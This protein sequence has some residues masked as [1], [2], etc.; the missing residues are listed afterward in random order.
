MYGIVNELRKIK[1]NKKHKH[2]LKNTPFEHILDAILH[3]KLDIKHCRKSDKDIEKIITLFN[4]GTKKFELNNIQ[5]QLQS[6]DV[7]LIFEI[8]DGDSKIEVGKRANKGDTEFIRR[9][10]KEDVELRKTTIRAEI[11]RAH[12]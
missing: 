12:V 8:V 5:I 10:F 2:M 6:T 11:G 3:D 7:Q 4:R 1:L 9:R